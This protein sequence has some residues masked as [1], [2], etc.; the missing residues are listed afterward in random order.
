MTTIFDYNK[1]VFD[2]FS[3]FYAKAPGKARKA[4]ARM[5]NQF[6]FGVKDETFLHMKRTMTVRNPR[7]VKSSVRV[8]MARSTNI[9]RQKS[10][11]GSIKRARFSGWIEQEEKVPDD[12]GRSQSLLARGGNWNKKVKPSVKM[13]PGR[14]FTSMGDFD[15]PSGKGKFPAYFRKIKKGNKGKPFLVKRKYKSLK[16]GLYKFIRGKMMI[17]QNFEKKKKP[18]K[19]NPWMTKSRER[20][21]RRVNLNKEW[22]KS[23]AFITKKKKF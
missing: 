7:F 2:S 9:D 6:A 11:T 12:R 17:L 14:N 21:F 3:R 18:V 19:L 22:E 13:K 1:K 4:T 15:L 16:R 20:Y 5:L 8:I 10:Q 23:I